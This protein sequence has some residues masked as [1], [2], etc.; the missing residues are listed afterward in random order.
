MDI[1]QKI[2]FGVDDSES[3]RQA[4]TAAGAL[5]KDRKS[6]NITLFYGAPDPQLSSLTKLLRLTPTAVEEYRK[7]LSLQEH[8]V[9]ERTEEALIGSG[10]EAE[11]VMIRG[12]GKCHDPAATIL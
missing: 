7:V 1:E 5:I 6:S 4:V 2:L 8:R 3:A 11:S 10:L 9:L 12:E